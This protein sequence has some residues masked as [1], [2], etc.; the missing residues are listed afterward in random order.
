MKQTIFPHRI[1][2]LSTMGFSLAS[3]LIVALSSSE[4][5][6]LFGVVCASISSGF[7]EITFLSLTA[8]Y[9]KSTVSAW[10]S[11][12]GAAGVAG[13]LIYAGLRSFL[14]PKVTLIIQIF[15]PVIT[16][17]AYFFLLTPK[18][19]SELSSP[20]ERHVQQR[21]S[22]NDSTSLM[23][24]DESILHTKEDEKK[25]LVSH[26]T[27]DKNKPSGP[28]GEESK[29]N[30]TQEDTTPLIS[31]ADQQEDLGAFNYQDKQGVDSALPKT[32]SL[33]LQHFSNITL[34]NKE[35]VSLLW[36][37]VKYIP[38]LFKYMVP[39]FLVYFAEYGI[40]QTFFELLY[41]PNT[42]ISSY[43]LDQQTQ[44]RWLQV[45]YQVGVLISRSSVSIIYI[46][47]FW[48]LSLLQVSLTCWSQ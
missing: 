7:G 5:V 45:I 11:G 21:S 35:E 20:Q 2:L 33:F 26:G 46:K 18:Q 47:H 3:F 48:I 29:G 28:Y 34:F 30:V 9:H 10:S 42:H 15:I 23:S 13:A 17:V 25:P 37:H 24:Q 43:C 27:P 36:D 39:L 4:P 12:T 31:H 6:V 41:A 8:H 1:R 44:Y 16:L 19:S 40:N 14:S 32:K 22:D 38:H